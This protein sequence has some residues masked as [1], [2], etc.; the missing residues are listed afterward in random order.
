MLNT[1]LT[2]GIYVLA[3][4]VSNPNKDKRFKDAWL[5]AAVWKKGMRFV[6]ESHRD[7]RLGAE[8]MVS[9]LRPFNQDS[10]SIVYLFHAGRE[11]ALL[12]LIAN[13]EEDTSK[14]AQFDFWMKSKTYLYKDTLEDRLR[15]AFLEGKIDLAWLDAKDAEEQAE[16]EAHD[17]EVEARKAAAAAA[18]K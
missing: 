12:L 13:L 4:D 10:S 16:W 7:P 5:K 9:T 1:E 3:A 6:V 8:G 17:A 15:R 11:P 14:G 2:P 18:E